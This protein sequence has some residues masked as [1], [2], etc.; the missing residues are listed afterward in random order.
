MSDLS[1]VSLDLISEGNCHDNAVA[2]SF[3]ANLQNEL[4]Y[5]HDFITRQDARSAIFDYIELFYDRK[6]LYQTLN[7][8]TQFNMKLCKLLLNHVSMKSGSLLFFISDKT[9]TLQ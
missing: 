7:Y 9:G 6:R 2:E 8:Q 5:H 3:F 4:T 1:I